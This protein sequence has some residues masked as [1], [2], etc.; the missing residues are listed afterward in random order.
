[1]TLDKKWNADR[2]TD[3]A[4]SGEFLSLWCKLAKQHLVPAMLAEQMVEEAHERDFEPC[5]GMSVALDRVHLDPGMAMVSQNEPSVMV[6]IGPYT[7]TCWTREITDIRPECVNARPRN[8]AD[9][10]RYFKIHGRIHCWC[11]PEEWRDTLVDPTS[12]EPY[13]EP[14]P[15]ESTP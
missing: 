4:K 1:M 9:G 13:V 5:M 15:E 8:F 6:R 10:T 7:L 2:V 3:H 14:E 12:W 11:I